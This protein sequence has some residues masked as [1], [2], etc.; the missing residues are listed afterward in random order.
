MIEDAPLETEKQ[1][2]FSATRAMVAPIATLGL[3]CVG[4]YMFAKD[5]AYFENGQ[6][7]LIACFLAGLVGSF[8]AFSRKKFFFAVLAVALCGAALFAS[9]KKYEWRRD[10]LEK[11]ASGNPFVLEP[12][13]TAY[14]PYEEYLLASWLGK[15]DWVRFAQDCIEP[16]N[17]PEKV[18]SSI[19]AI[20]QKYNIDVTATLNAYRNKMAQTAQKI[21]DGKITKKIDYMNCLSSK[22]CA[23]VPLLPPDVDADM[24]DPESDDFLQIRKPFWQLVNDKTITP[25]I[26]AWIS[27]CRSLGKT[28]ALDPGQIQGQTSKQA[29]TQNQKK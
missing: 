25:E 10:Y 7:G 3:G 13:I 14:P 20:L 24:I 2:E 12:Y 21:V 19:S 17:E 8:F 16:E 15:P 28:G 1:E 4:F 23:E 26:C 29:Q 27:L 18:C 5:W 11:G 6:T 22:Q 9:Q